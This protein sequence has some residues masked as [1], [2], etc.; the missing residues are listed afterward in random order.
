MISSSIKIDKDQY[1]SNL[2][3]PSTYQQFPYHFHLLYHQSFIST[4]PTHDL[5]HLIAL[6]LSKFVSVKELVCIFFSFLMH[7]R[8]NKYQSLYI[9]LKAWK[10]KLMRY[11]QILETKA[12]GEPSVQTDSMNH[13]G[14]HSWVLYGWRVFTLHGHLY[15]H[16]FCCMERTWNPLLY[17]HS[18][19][20]QLLREREGKGLNFERE[21]NC[22]IE[23]VSP[24]TAEWVASS[25]VL[26]S[27][28]EDSWI[29]WQRA[30]QPSPSCC[31]THQPQLHWSQ[32]EW[33][34]LGHTL[35]MALMCYLYLNLNIS[36][37]FLQ[38][39]ED[40]GLIF[41]LSISCLQMFLHFFFIVCAG[42]CYK[43]CLA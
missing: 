26:L 40:W 34:A 4:S 9:T 42:W 14:L 8:H 37:F 31:L 35:L 36:P 25:A 24:R 11:R 41:L 15:I 20:I 13:Q 2:F 29:E 32:Q 18:I 6:S 19:T 16:C 22:E 43:V 27:W 38:A 5:S 10:G 30:D 17:T 39:Y 23:L 12:W 21:Y 7:C 1:T 28:P 33:L 3:T